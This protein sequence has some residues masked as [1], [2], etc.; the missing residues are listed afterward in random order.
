M[1]GWHLFSRNPHQDC[2]SNG[3]NGQIDRIWQSKTISFARKF[4]LCKSLVTAILLN[5]CEPGPH[6]DSERRIQAFE[7]QRLCLVL[8]VSY[9]EHKTNDWVRGKINFLV[10]PQEPLLATVKRRKLA[11][12]VHVT[13]H[14]SL[15]KTILQGTLEGGR[16]RGR[17]RKCWMVNIKEWTSLSMPELLARASCRKDWKRISVE[18]SLVSPR[19][20]YRSRD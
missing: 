14:D 8:R 4:K 11:W 5:G 16:S 17:Q 20:P 19:R 13:C 10:D 7:T 12:F 9:L 1:Q 6:A 2:L 3:S 18:S 15:S